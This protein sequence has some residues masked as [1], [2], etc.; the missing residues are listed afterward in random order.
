M[1]QIAKTRPSMLFAVAV[2]LIAAAAGLL[3]QTTTSI[4]SGTVTDSSGAIVAGAKVEVRNVGTGIT[5]ALT[6]D[7][8]GRF[9]AP[10]LNIGDYEVQASRAGFQTVVRK[11][12]STSIGAEAIIDIMLPV[13]QSQQVVTVDAQVSQVDTTTS[14]LGNAVTK[15]QIEELPLGTRNQTQLLSLAPGVG[16]SAPVGGS[17]YGRQ[18]NYSISGS[19]ANGIMFLID[20][21]NLQTY[22]GHSTGSAATGATLGIEAI[23]DYQTLT[24][25]YSAQFGGNGGLVNAASKNGTNDI[26]GSLYFLLTNTGMLASRNTFD[27]T[28]FPGHLGATA[29]PNRRGIFGGSFGGPIKKN[30]AFIFANYEG[31][32]QAG[33]ASQI[34]TNLPDANAHNGYLPCATAGAKYGCNAATNLAYVGFAPLVQ[35]IMNLLPLPSTLTSAGLGNLTMV[36][37]SSGQDDYLLTRFDYTFSSRDN[38]FVRYVRD[39][40][41]AS[42]VVPNPG[43]IPIAGEG[44]R[45]ANHFVTIEEDHTISASLINLARISFLRPFE[46]ASTTTPPIA[47]LQAVNTLG[48]SQNL[49][50]INGNTIG[51]TNLVP[52]RMSEQNYQV[53]NDVIWTRGSHNVK[54]GGSFAVVADYTN[55]NNTG[56]YWTFASVLGFLTGTPTTLQG[57]F[58]G[59]LDNFRDSVQKQFMPYINDEWKFSRKLTINM[60]VRY[61]WLSNPGARHGLLTNVTNLQTNTN[62]VPVPT[63]M[64]NNPT[65]KNF[66]PRVGFAFDP[67]SDHKT[68]IRGGFGIFYSE[69]TAHIWLNAYW[70][71]APYI[72][73]SV[74][75]PSWPVPFSGGATP[76]LPNAGQFGFSWVDKTHTPY[77]MQENLTIQREVARGTIFTVS[78]VGTRG[79]HLISQKDY[80]FPQLINGVYGTPQSNGV[81]LPNVRPNPNFNYLDLRSTYANSNYNSLQSSLNH[82]FANHFQLQVAYT[83]SKS[84][85]TSSGDQGPDNGNGSNQVAMNPFNIAG[86]YGRS[87]FDFTHVFRTNAMY[88]LPFTRNELVKGWRVSSIVSAQTGQPF[89]IF[90]GIDRTGVGGPKAIPARPNLVPGGN[91]DPITGNISQ[92]YN[93]SNFAIQPIGTFGNLG[94]NTA[95][96]PKLVLVNLALLKRFAVPRISEKF[97][98]EF[99]AEAD[100]ALNHPNYALPNSSL[101]IAGGVNGTPNP[102]AGKITTTLGGAGIGNRQVLLAIKASF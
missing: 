38:L 28:I 71:Q 12:I 5:S 32:R 1:Y 42:T 39:T 44:D 93:P 36:T 2:M 19:R 3:A 11:G 50:A 35:P 68:S 85:D 18:E 65:T 10:D 33:S 29:P 82:R 45:T 37:P 40:A 79:V 24:N 84:L 96:G 61:E 48:G 49:V 41:L 91:P 21:T 95:V 26:H 14:A 23:G 56:A 72:N 60:G 9:R 54:F 51:P 34:Y 67:F 25:A 7:A 76:P 87:N 74:T 89:S 27:T 46:N 99:R 43:T 98:V 6:T 31:V 69:L 63:V 20:N 15:T 58:P 88:E 8:Q 55:Q 57:G 97:A 75:N 22:N 83:Y 94:R 73:G 70:T 101:F 102:T 30:K 90:D 86:E 16:Y 81:A 4:L 66:A 47:A 64:P 78:Y 17:N 77:A 53:M 92:W 59:N 52:Y 80:N 13:G 62:W 100:D